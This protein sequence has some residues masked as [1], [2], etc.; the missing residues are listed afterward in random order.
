M[1]TDLGAGSY[2][3]DY[4][5]N[6]RYESVHTRSYWHNLPLIQGKEQ[7]ATPNRCEVKEVFID[8]DKAEIS[9]ELSKLYKLQELQSYQRSISSDLGKGCVTILD[10]FS[11]P[12][13][14]EIEEGFISTIKPIISE[15]GSV[16]WEGK[17]GRVTL[18]Y[19]TTQC[20]AFVKEAV[21][22]NHRNDKEK[23][24]RLGLKLIQ[25]QE[26]TKLLIQFFL[27]NYKV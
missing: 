12:T 27:Q 10:Y 22:I 25:K 2:T 4:F 21:A 24:Y 15:P 14:L 23:V 7:V 11:S 13:P 8:G 17:M 26:N 19:E 6:N 5:S 16:M 3:A 9:M 20:K 1:I 18:R